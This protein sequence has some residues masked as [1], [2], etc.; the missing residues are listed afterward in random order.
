MK[1]AKEFQFVKS[2]LEKEGYQVESRIDFYG[3]LE[4]YISR[5]GLRGPMLAFGDSNSE[6]NKYESLTFIGE[7]IRGNKKVTS[8]IRQQ[9]EEELERA[10][11][12]AAAAAAKRKKYAARVFREA[13][14]AGIDFNKIQPISIRA[15]KALVDLK[16]EGFWLPSKIKARVKK[17]YAWKYLEDVTPRVVFQARPYYTLNEVKWILLNLPDGPEQD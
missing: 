11:E 6:G 16:K 14:K 10:K 3:I 8:S 13:K 2:I 4:Y 15:L 9:I 7:R 5:D 17:A 12:K 1:V